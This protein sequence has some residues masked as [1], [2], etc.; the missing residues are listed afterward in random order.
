MDASLEQM[1][2]TEQ[3]EIKNDLSKL[4][5]YKAEWLKE[6]LFD[7]FTTPRYLS[8]LSTDVPCVLVGGRGTG[9]TTVLRGLSYQGQF[10]LGGEVAEAVANW[11]HYGLY[12][13]VNSTRVAAFSGPE[14]SEER[15]QKLFGHYLNLMFVDLLL[16]FGEWFESKTNSKMDTSG[17]DFELFA[18]SLSLPHDALG[19]VG[20]L[21]KTVSLSVV[22]FEEYIN[23]IEDERAPTL[24][25]LGSPIDLAV[26]AFRNTRTFEGKQFSFLIDEY[27]NLKE[28][29][30]QVANTLI[31]HASDAYTFKIGVRELGWRCR[32][33]LNPTEQLQSPADYR[34]FNISEELLNDEFADFGEEVCNA[35]LSELRKTY[36]DVPTSISEIFPSLSLQ[37]ESL[38]LGVGVLADRIEENL[39]TLTEHGA[40]YFQSLTPLEKYFIDARAHAANRSIEEI[41]EEASNDPRWKSK[42]DNHSHA[43]LFTIKKG[44]RGIRKFYCGWR[45]LALL[46]NGNLRYLIELVDASIALHLNSGRTLAERV[47]PEMQTKAAQQVGKKNLGE[48]EGLSIHGAKLSKLLLGLGRVFGVM[49]EDAVGH[50]PEVNQFELTGEIGDGQVDEL[51]D[52]AVMHLALVRFTGTKA[53]GLDTKDY[54]YAVHPIYAPFFGFSHRKKRKMHISREE[55]QLLVDDTKLGIDSILSK[56]NRSHHETL[57]DQ[58]TLFEDYFDGHS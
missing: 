9:K 45:V 36:P 17:A 35:R 40:E 5:A 39:G 53:A 7:L 38:K 1:S 33:T 54:D 46:A 23:N 16:E 8:K 22:A 43:L 44:K 56:S 47:P 30:Q 3:N 55:I 28:P 13:R 49:A 6:K 52:N 58:L 2:M 12:L 18:R 27:E 19:S 26:A 34:L 21:R 50:A 11:R 25:M 4:F 31:K 42:F 20:D 37:D 51:V 14:V 48:L 29:Q 24:S 10:A 15:W 57:P 32:T 41:I